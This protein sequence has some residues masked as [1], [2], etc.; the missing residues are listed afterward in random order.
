[1]AVIENVTPILRVK[2]LNASRHYYT[3]TL[4]FSLDWETD[5]A[6]SVSRNSKSIMLVEWQQGQPG[7][8]IWIGVNDA[9]V[10][11]PNFRPRAPTSETRR[12]I[13]AGPT[14]SKL[15]TQMVTF[16]ASALNRRV[17]RMILGYPLLTM[18]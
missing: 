7:T 1:V 13:S 11:L 12:G 6:M 2:D 18:N 4:G 8:W 5:G 3:Q 17:D 15:K 14:S 16:F 10:F 9:D